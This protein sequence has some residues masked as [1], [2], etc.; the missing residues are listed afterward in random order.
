MIVNKIHL[1]PAVNA[2]LSINPRKAQLVLDSVHE[3]G[4]G[5]RREDLKHEEKR[6]WKKLKPWRD[7]QDPSHKNPC[8]P[9][10]SLNAPQT[11]ISLNLANSVQ[12]QS[13]SSQRERLSAAQ[14]AGTVGHNAKC[15]VYQYP[16]PGVSHHRGGGGQG[17]C[18]TTGSFIQRL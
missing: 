4:G 18:V 3:H 2:E 17:T 10:V 7:I 13:K 8:D 5:R 11:N 14:R 16:S 1:L 15:A 6:Q 9:A 12:P